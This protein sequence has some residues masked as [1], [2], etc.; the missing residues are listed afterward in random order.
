MSA[1]TLST[2]R[3]EYGSTC[4]PTRRPCARAAAI[5]AGSRASSSEPQPH[6]EV[7]TS[8]TPAPA[9]S[10]ICADTTRGSPLEYGPRSG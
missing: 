2:V 8:P 3:P 1:P 9:I 6:H 4:A 10:S 5:T 7:T